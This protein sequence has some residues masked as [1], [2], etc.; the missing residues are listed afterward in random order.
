[1]TEHRLQDDCACR[2]GASIV[3]KH[4]RETICNRSDACMLNGLVDG[5]TTK[6]T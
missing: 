6:E 4:Q 3:D 5:D 2:K 1:M